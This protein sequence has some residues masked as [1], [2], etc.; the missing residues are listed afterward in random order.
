MW[1]FTY[2]NGV[3]SHSDILGTNAFLKTKCQSSSAELQKAPSSILRLIGRMMY[4]TVLILKTVAFCNLI[5]IDKDF[6]S[7]NI[8]K[9]TLNH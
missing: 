7:T 3:L 6:E 4:S 8:V 2:L 5:D 1:F 9:S